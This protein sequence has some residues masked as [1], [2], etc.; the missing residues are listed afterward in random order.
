M[1]PIVDAGSRGV[2]LGVARDKTSGQVTTLRLMGEVHQVWGLGF[3]VYVLGF[4]V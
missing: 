3:G 1:D 2:Y 4:R